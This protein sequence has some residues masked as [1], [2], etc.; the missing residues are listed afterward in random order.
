VA[1]YP[2]LVIVTAAERQKAPLLASA[3]KQ[4]VDVVGNER[5]F[6]PFV[7]VFKA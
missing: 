2:E 6:V 1:S 3:N 7:P 4:V 5:V